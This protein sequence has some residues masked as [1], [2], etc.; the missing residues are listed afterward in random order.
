[1]CLQQPTSIAAVSRVCQA[2][3]GN[4]DRAAKAFTT[5]SFISAPGPLYMALS[6]SLPV[7]IFF[8]HVP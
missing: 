3:E 5:G 1:M 8:L 7:V 6:K 2:E 4:L